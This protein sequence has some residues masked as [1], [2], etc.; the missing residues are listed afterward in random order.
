MIWSYILD[1]LREPLGFIPQGMLIALAAVCAGV[2]LQKKMEKRRKDIPGSRE[3]GKRKAGESGMHFWG[4]IFCAVLYGYV[5]LQISF[6]S[7]EPG[8]RRG[9]NLEL[10]GTW[11]PGAQARA[12]V[13][14]N[15]LMFIPFGFLAPE[16]S[17]PLK[18]G[19]WC[20]AAGLLCSIG[21]ET[22]QRITERGYFQLDD[23]VMNT[24]GTFLGWFGWKVFRRLAGC[25]KRTAW[26]GDAGS[27]DR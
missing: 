17:S 18:K 3:N 19:I 16:L 4:R 9:I 5:I 27:R 14:E 1:D 24:L 25:R 10:L 12:Y 15:V 26:R 6:L 8:T 21:I 23:M 20:T 11:G 7:R 2:F 13:V 22:A